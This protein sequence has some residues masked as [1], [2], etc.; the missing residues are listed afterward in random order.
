M[1]NDI[2]LVSEAKDDLSE[3]TA[4]ERTT[5]IRQIYVQLTHQ[6]V[7]ITLNRSPLKRTQNSEV[8]YWKLRVGNLRAY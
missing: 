3:L 4:G 6:A 5:I 2:K 8:V 7:L 1:A